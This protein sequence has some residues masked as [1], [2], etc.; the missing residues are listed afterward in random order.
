MADGK[1]RPLRGHLLI[2]TLLPLL[3]EDTVNKGVMFD[4]FWCFGNLTQLEVTTNLLDTGFLK[5]NKT[6]IRFQDEMYY[7]QI[8]FQA[9]FVI[10]INSI[11]IWLY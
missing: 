5:V 7:K 2:T 8:F 4:L 3:S 11:I 1:W 10:V 6:E 9:I